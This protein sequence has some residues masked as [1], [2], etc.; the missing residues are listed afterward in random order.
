MHRRYQDV[1]IPSEIIRTVVTI[2][3]AGGFSKAAEKLG[4]SQPAI[5]AQ[6]KRLQVLVGG[7]V[8]E[9][10][11]AGVTLTGRGQLVVEHARKI[12]AAN[13]Q[14]LSLG[15]AVKN[16]Q[17]IRVGMTTLY[18]DALLAMWTESEVPYP[19]N[20]YCDQSEEILKGV[21]DG[22][23]DLACCINPR[24]AQS[25]VIAEWDEHFT[26]VRNPDFYLRHEQP[27]PLVAW[28]GNSTEHPMIRALENAGVPYHV[29]FTSPDNHARLAAVAAGLGITALPSRYIPDSL[30]PARDISLPPVPCQKGGICARSGVDLK[31]LE[32]IVE[33]LAVLRPRASDFATAKLSS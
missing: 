14:I 15:G 23:L 2:A 17:P 29:V 7:A 19:T 25:D 20:I 18:V 31:E 10:T 11:T 16:R 32:W 22:Y 28:A 3:E 33:I 12:L 30:V 1:N 24:A 27:V 21:T 13:D 5:T 26:W 8:F 6:I 9:R 4:L